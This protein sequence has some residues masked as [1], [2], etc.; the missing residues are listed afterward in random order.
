LGIEEHG[1]RAS[2]KIE[3]VT[4]GLSYLLMV[5]TPLEDLEDRQVAGAISREDMGA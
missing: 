3:S 5:D 1:L 2:D 4:P